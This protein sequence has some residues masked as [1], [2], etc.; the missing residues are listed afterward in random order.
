MEYRKLGA[1]MLAGALLA[2][3]TAGVSL[4]QQPKPQAEGHRGEMR[5]RMTPEQRT[6]R[7]AE[8]LRTVLQLRPD[9][10]AAL[11]TF[12]QSSGPKGGEREGMRGKH[13]EM[14]KMTTPQ[15]LDHMAERMKQRQ[16]RFEQHAAATKRFYAQLSPAQQKA[17]DA[18]GPRGRGKGGH[19]G[20]HGHGMGEHGG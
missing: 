10:E 13:E 9:Q 2:G 4:A 19:R 18:M 7:R 14:A 15:R 6:E 12:L 17:F 16:A 8:H 5:Q 3:T 11:R 20:G 1:V